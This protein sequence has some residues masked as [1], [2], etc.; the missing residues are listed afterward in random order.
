MNF[1]GVSYAVQ[2]V[3]NANRIYKESECEKGRQNDNGGAIQ[4]G[5]YEC[6][7]GDNYYYGDAKIENGI[8]YPGTWMEGGGLFGLS[9]KMMT[10]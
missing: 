2:W 1:I 5:E 4:V 10:F 3:D 9:K 6:M 8:V 7:S